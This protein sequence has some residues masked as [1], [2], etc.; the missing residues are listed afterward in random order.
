[1]LAENE[2]RNI[3]FWG[4]SVLFE[5]HAVDDRKFRIGII[6]SDLLHDR[7]L[8]KSHADDQIEAFLCERPHRRLDRSGIA[9]LYVIQAYRHIFR[10]TLYALPSRG[11]EGAIILA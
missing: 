10:C 7:S 8:G 4:L 5:D 9:G 3:G 2:R 1:M 6:L 11:I